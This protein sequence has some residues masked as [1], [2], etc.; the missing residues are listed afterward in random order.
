MLGFIKREIQKWEDSIID[1]LKEK[2][3]SYVPG[4]GRIYWTSGTE[5]LRI[6]PDPDVLKRLKSK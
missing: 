6:E 3:S 1:Q 4:L 5:N 2:G